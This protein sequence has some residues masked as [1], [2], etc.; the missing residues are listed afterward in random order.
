[1]LVDL[2]VDILSKT[3]IVGA[4]FV[5]QKSKNRGGYG[6]IYYNGTVVTAHRLMYYAVHGTIDG[7]IICHTC[8][9]RLCVNP[10]HLY[11]GTHKSN[12]DD[13]VSRGRHWG[14]NKK[15]CVNGHEYC[16]ENTGTDHRGHRFCLICSRSSK[17]KYKNKLT[18][19]AS[20]LP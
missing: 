14:A 2:A 8:D 6:Q 17:A 7:A 1:M 11:L 3:R 10:A 12:A 5:W 20:T 19:I 18:H 9:N 13:M 15:F 4:C 16:K